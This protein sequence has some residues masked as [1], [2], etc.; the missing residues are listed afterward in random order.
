MPSDQEKNRI[1][2]TDLL[3]RN[4]LMEADRK[5]MEDLNLFNLKYAKYIKCNKEDKLTANCDIKDLTCCGASDK[6][7]KTILDAQTAL[8]TD[9]ANINKL[10]TGFKGTLINPTEYESNHKKILDSEEQIK[11]LRHELDMKLREIYKI[12]N[13]RVLD[14]VGQYDSVMYTSILF[15]ILAT[16][17]L[18][19]TFTKL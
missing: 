4:K 17:L 9:I 1:E 14:S 15:T 16:S 2:Q 8:N 7:M 10:I 11:E 18:Y 5:L 13:A 12:D 6:D 19:L 3:E